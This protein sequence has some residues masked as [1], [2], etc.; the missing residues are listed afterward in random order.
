MGIQ[1]Q[2]TFYFNTLHVFRGSVAFIVI[3]FQRSAFH[4]ILIQS[5]TLLETQNMNLVLHIRVS[6]HH[7]NL[8]EGNRMASTA[9]CS[10]QIAIL[11]SM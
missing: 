3:I 4:S 1:L 8:I 7:S 6:A 10:L 9:S 5:A 11:Y 2:F